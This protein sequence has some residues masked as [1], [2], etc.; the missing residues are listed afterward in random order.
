MAKQKYGYCPKCDA[1]R[2]LMVKTIEQTFPVRGEP[3]TVECEVA[4]C[5][6]CGEEVFDRELDF[7]NL[8]RAYAEYR[9]RKGLPTP[10]EIVS[11]RERYGLSQR[12][13]AKLLGWSP[14]T[15]YRYEKG[16]VPTPGHG[17]VLKMLADP[18]E[19][20]KLLERRGDKLSPREFARVKK[21]VKDL[22]ERERE[23]LLR[24]RVEN[25]LGSY[26]PGI[27]S[28]FRRLNFEKLVGMIAFFAGN[29][30]I[31]KTALMKLLWYADFLHFKRHA[32]SISGA[33]YAA[34]PYGPALDRWELCLALAAETGAITT[35][36]E[37]KF[38]YEGEVV[39]AAVEFNKDIFTPEELATLEEVKHRLGG[40]NS[41]ALTERSHEEEAWKLTPRGEIISYEHALR[42]R[43]EEE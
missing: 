9:R 29:T 42:L 25:L 18:A 33:R 34:L 5:R 12:A 40:L 36:F 1:E 41:K 15:V 2:E 28:G 24:A 16:A 21:R 23:N 6:E 37:L 14:A 19:M 4:F 8:E 39:R 30:G 27:E 7:A 35:E 13:L 43:W 11:L 31:F 10:Q 26:P 20:A 22:L 17:E 3:V 38:D 32:V